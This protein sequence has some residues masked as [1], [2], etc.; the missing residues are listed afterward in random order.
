MCHGSDHWYM[1]PSAWHAIPEPRQKVIL[2]RILNPEPSIGE[3]VDFSILDG[4]RKHII[5]LIEQALSRGDFPTAQFPQIHQLLD[6]EKGK[7]GD[8]TSN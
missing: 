2:K 5:E 3:P 7:F 6:R 8:L 4:P 1:T